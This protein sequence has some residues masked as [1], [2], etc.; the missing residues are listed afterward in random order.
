MF[1]PPLPFVHSVPQHHV[2]FVLTRRPLFHFGFSLPFSSAS[3][4]LF[5]QDRLPSILDALTLDHFEIHQ[6]MRV[7]EE[8]RKKNIGVNGSV[9]VSLICTFCHFS[10]KDFCVYKTPTAYYRAVSTGVASR[11]R[12]RHLRPDWQSFGP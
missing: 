9:H 1:S 2:P 10:S 6:N 7:P 4:C 5:N 12:C 3:H 11:V 8:K